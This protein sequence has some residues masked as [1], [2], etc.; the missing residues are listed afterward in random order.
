MCRAL[1]AEI[2]I[3]VDATV[4]LCVRDEQSDEDAAS[5]FLGIIMA[6]MANAVESGEEVEILC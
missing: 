4:P 3:R 2:G 1:A 6:V 5:I